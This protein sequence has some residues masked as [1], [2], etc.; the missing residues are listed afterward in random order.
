[1][2]QKG[3]LSPASYAAL[4]IAGAYAVPPL[5]TVGNTTEGAVAASDM[6]TWLNLYK[7]GVTTGRITPPP[8]PPPPPAPA[9]PSPDCL[10]NESLWYAYAPDWDVVASAAGGTGPL[11]R[12]KAK[13]TFNCKEG[14]LLKKCQAKSTSLPPADVRCYRP[15][16]TVRL[17]APPQ[18]STIKELLLVEPLLPLLP[19]PP[20]AEHSSRSPS[21]PLASA[22][23]VQLAAILE[24]VYHGSA[25]CAVAA[26]AVSAS[27]GAKS[28]TLAELAHVVTRHAACMRE[29]LHGE[30]IMGPL[31]LHPYTFHGDE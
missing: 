6:E 28:F 22:T 5:L 23:R 16:A 26:S 8:P 25:A 12:A 30:R 27:A 9:P 21:R 11:L 1:M 18:P 3:D 15:G 2:R 24:S 17:K 20:P 31:G 7:E 29:R 19:S 4:H 13:P 14:A 10:T